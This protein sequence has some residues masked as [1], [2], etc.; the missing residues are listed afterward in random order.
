[1][2]KQF[3]KEYLDYLESPK[4]QRKR[5]EVF[6]VQG[7]RCKVCESSKRINVHH[8][9]YERLYDELP[10]DLMVLC[11]PCHD[12]VHELGGGFHGVVRLAK[13]TETARAKKIKAMQ[14]KENR[15][16]KA[17][18]KW[19]KAHPPKQEK[20]AFIPKIIIRKAKRSQEEIKQITADSINTHP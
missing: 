12:L 2:G 4:W 14:R 9:T 1:M 5:Q 19:L 10:E 17:L 15:R 13:L 7:R 11:H 18:A 3:S 8:L 6:K 16:K 20:P